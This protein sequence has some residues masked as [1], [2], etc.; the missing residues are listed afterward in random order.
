MIRLFFNF[1][2][3]KLLSLPPQFF[4]NCLCVGRAG[5]W[6]GGGGGGVVP[7]VP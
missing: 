3:C 1:Y 6:G 5:G 2:W 7:G 4:D